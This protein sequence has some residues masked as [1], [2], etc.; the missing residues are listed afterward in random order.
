M[1]TTSDMP[2]EAI[3]ATSRVVG[4]RIPKYGRVVLKISG[5]A[6]M[7]SRGYGI[8]TGTV[9]QIAEQLRDVH[10][11]GVELAVVVGGGNIIRGVEISSQGLDRGLCRDLAHLPFPSMMIP[12]CTGI[13]G[14]GLVGIAAGGNGRSMIRSPVES[15][16]SYNG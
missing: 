3:A 14:P 10:A 15:T 13:E 9:Y 2:H 7:G 16:H 11:L 1:D 5:E 4:K 8:D 6:L 12:T